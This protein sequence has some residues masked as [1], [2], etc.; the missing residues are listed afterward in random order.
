MTTELPNF[1]D[2]F[3]DGLWLGPNNLVHLFL[4]TAD[5]RAFILELEGVNRLA[6]T[7]V[8][9]GNIILDLIVRTADAMTAADIQNTYGIDD[10]SPHVSRALAAAKDE[11]LQALEINPSY[12]AEGIILFRTWKLI[13]RLP[14][15]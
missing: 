14:Q 7:E 13:P 8:K 11:Q 6:L 4:R 12:G 5:R 1:H 9:Q 2:G 10:D 3:F 15:P